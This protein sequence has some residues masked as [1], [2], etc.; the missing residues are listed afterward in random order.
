MYAIGGERCEAII[1]EGDEAR[2]RVPSRAPPIS[3]GGGFG[4]G[5]QGEMSGKSTRMGNMVTPAFLTVR[6]R[7]IRRGIRR[8]IREI[9][10]VLAGRCAAVLVRG[11]GVREVACALTFG[12]RSSSM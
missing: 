3:Y 10:A 8:E 7:E 11:Q 1:E 12:D 6:R 4:D 2:D 9:L 5:V